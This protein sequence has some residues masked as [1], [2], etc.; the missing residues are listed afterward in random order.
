MA[1]KGTIQRI[2]LGVA[3]NA[4]VPWSDEYLCRLTWLAGERYVRRRGTT[5]QFRIYFDGSCEEL[6]DYSEPA[7]FTIKLGQLLDPDPEEEEEDDE[8][9]DAEEE[10][11]ESHDDDDE[12]EEDEDQD[13][14]DLPEALVPF[15]SRELAHRQFAQPMQLNPQ[16]VVS[17]QNNALGLAQ[18]AY[19]GSMQSNRLLVQEMRAEMS[20]MVRDI[21]AMAEHTNKATIDV[22]RAMNDFH[23]REA[24][25]GRERIATLETQLHNMTKLNGKAYE[26]QQELARQGWQ[27]FLDGM[28]LKSDA[29]DDRMEWAQWLQGHPVM[30]AQNQPA[31][32]ESGGGS[33]V[34][35]MMAKGIPVVLAGLSMMY[36]HKGKDKEADFLANMAQ[37]FA[38]PVDEFEAE[39]EDDDFVDADVAP[40]PYPPPNGHGPNGAKGTGP[41]PGMEPTPFADRCREF[42]VKIGEQ[43]VAALRKM[44][45]PDAWRGFQ[46]ACTARVDDVAIKGLL[47]MHAIVEADLNLM[48][49]LAQHLSEDEVEEILT[50][51][52]A[53]KKAA[54]KR[55]KPRRPPARPTPEAPPE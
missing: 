40:P 44:L 31:P 36:R 9:D 18:R 14:R 6:G 34:A 46:Q 51:V 5:C 1:R 38:G 45:P 25:A 55:T 32:Q 42:R 16:F 35:G 39:E 28:R 30:Q 13:G 10:D 11:D 21:K 26:N 24:E 17:L 52:D 22:M 27:A 29:V 15:E 47:R 43:K 8:E 53:I 4:S 7:T 37:R 23:I 12:E 41:T 49:Q 54:P 33:G 20:S 50:M 2:E 48:M 3:P 19:E